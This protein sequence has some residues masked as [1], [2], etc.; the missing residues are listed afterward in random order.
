MR[1]GKESVLDKGQNS[2]QNGDARLKKRSKAGRAILVFDS[3]TNI[4]DGEKQSQESTS[5]TRKG[6]RKGN[7]MSSRTGKAGNLMSSPKKL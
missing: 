3:D 2:S 1:G 6:K 4:N 7:S 5:K